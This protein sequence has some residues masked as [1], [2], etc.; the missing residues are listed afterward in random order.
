[1]LSSSPLKTIDEFIAYLKQG[2]FRMLVVSNAETRDPRYPDIPILK[3][4][5]CE[6][7]PANGYIVVGPKGLLSD[8]RIQSALADSIMD[9]PTKCDDPEV[10]AAGCSMEVMETVRNALRAPENY[11]ADLDRDLMLVA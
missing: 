4:L 1:V 5:G 10:V 11:S 9:T 3:D 7:V 8:G 6:E 2:V